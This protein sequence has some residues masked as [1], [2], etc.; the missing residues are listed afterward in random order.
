MLNELVYEKSELIMHMIESM[1]DKQYF[2][3][4]IRDLYHQSSPFVTTKSFQKIFKQ[5]CG[6]KLKDFSMNWISATSCLTLSVSCVYNK[7]NN[8]LDLK[9]QQDSAMKDHFAFRKYL[10]E[11]VDLGDLLSRPFVRKD[12]IYMSDQQDQLKTSLKNLESIGK[13]TVDLKR[14]AQRWFVGEV[15]VMLYVTDGADI[16]T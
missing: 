5:V 3:R 9:L 15:N 13:F 14:E 11:G 7:K 8:S 16:S 12:K 6:M 10:Q 4:I 1:I 2:E